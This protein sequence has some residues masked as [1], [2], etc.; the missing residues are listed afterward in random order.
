MR[1][2]FVKVIW[3]QFTLRIAPIIVIVCVLYTFSIATIQNNSEGR[4]E[5]KKKYDFKRDPQLDALLKRKQR[6]I[7]V[8]ERMDNENRKR[9]NR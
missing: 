9:K 8:K 2:L 6:M 7:E 5:E 4:E 3:E 1:I